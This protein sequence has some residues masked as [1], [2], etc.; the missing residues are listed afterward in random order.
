M[1]AKTTSENAPPELV[2]QSIAEIDRRAVRVVAKRAT[3]PC[4]EHE[5][6][7]SGESLE[8]RGVIRGGENAVWWFVIGVVIFC[9]REPYLRFERR[10]AIGRG[11]DGG[12]IQPREPRLLFLP[13]LWSA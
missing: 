5:R 7:W 9:W 3:A 2:L 4:A 6:S 1:I 10:T 11:R 8:A 12:A 13:A